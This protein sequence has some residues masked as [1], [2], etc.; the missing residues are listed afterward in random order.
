[1]SFAS[2]V[3]HQQPIEILRRA[4]AED[5]LTTAYLFVGPPNV[6]KTLTAIEFARAV[7]CEERA[8]DL[9]PEQIDACDRCHNCVRI[10]QENHPDLLVVRPAVEVD[11]PVP[12]A[13]A[14]S[15]A[16]GQAEDDGA[17]DEADRARERTGKRAVYIELPDA[18]I[19]V[20]R[21]RSVVEYTYA[22]PAL[23]RRKFVVIVSAETLNNPAVNDA[24]ANTLLKTLEEPPADT[25]LILTTSRPNEILPTI[26]SRC[27]VVRFHALPG[28][29]VHAA[30]QERFPAVG[31]ELLDAAT[32]MAGG[33]FGLARRLVESPEL[34]RLRAELLDLA[35]ATVDAHLAECLALGE[36][37]MALPE[38]WWAASEGGE[39]SIATSDDERALITQ[40]L[41]EL[42]KKSP[43]RINRIQMEQILDVLQ[44]WYRDLL[45]VRGAASPDLVINVDRREQLRRLAP[46]YAPKGLVWASEVIEEVRRDLSEHNA[47]LRLACQALMVK[48]ISARRRR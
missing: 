28:T 11:V 25:T 8:P 7:N 47:N 24:A 34:A 15:S 44:T 26:I 13:R 39:A 38:A 12:G 46:A 21:A 3:G 45:L 33:R 41:E 29:Q 16:A 30:L 22:K 23:A 19:Q 20:E 40:A 36:R 5:R 18:L 37:L 17:E 48:L 6:G 2:I 4:I 42:A 1:M 31:T 9:P 43:D 35:A 14:A 32:A 10:G 27:Q